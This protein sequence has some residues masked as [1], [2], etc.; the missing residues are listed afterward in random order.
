MSIL[1]S[2]SKGKAAE[3]HQEQPFLTPHVQKM[4]QEPTEEKVQ[5]S[6]QAAPEEDQGA[7]M[8]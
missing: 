6:K 5:M 4:S 8:A 3:N 2:K 7:S 1:K